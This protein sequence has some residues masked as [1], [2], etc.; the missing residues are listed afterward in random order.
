MTKAISNLII[1]L[2]LSGSLSAQVNP[3]DY[4][5]HSDEIIGHDPRLPRQRLLSWEKPF[6]NY[7][8]FAGFMNI[9]NDK[10]SM[11]ICAPDTALYRIFYF[12]G[13][14][15]E[16]YLGLP[17]TREGEIR[18]KPN[19]ISSRRPQSKILLGVKLNPNLTNY[20]SSGIRSASKHFTGY[21]I[22]DS[23]AV[24]VVA[25]GINASN[26]N[27]YRYHV[28]VNDSLEIV[29][30]TTP[31][32]E[33]KHGAKQPYGLI[34]QFTVPD[35]QAVI[36]VV[37]I[38]D[39]SIRDGVMLD[40]RHNQR[41]VVNKIT[42]LDY[43]EPYIM[44]PGHTRRYAS[45][46]DK[47]TG[48]PTDL[49]FPVNSITQISLDFKDHEGLMYNVFLTKDTDGYKKVL[50]HGQFISNHYD[51]QLGKLEM[52]GKYEFTVI[53]EHYT[54]PSQMLRFSFTII[55]RIPDKEHI[56]KNT[57]LYIL[58]AI[59]FLA[60]LYL[61]Y[62]QK[63][64]RANRQKMMIS[65][66]LKSVRAQLNPHFMFNALTSIQNLMN[67][68]NTVGANHYLSKF[69]DLTRRVLN[70][71]TDELISLEDELKIIND[72]LQIEQL[73]FGFQ[74][75]VDVNEGIN[76]ANTEIPAMLMQPFIENAIKHGISSL[77]D[78]GKIDIGITREQNNL[79]LIIADNGKGFDADDMDSPGF[80]LKLGRERVA[81]L[82]QLYKD[83]LIEL[84]IS[85][86]T[87]GTRV[88]I[89]LNSWF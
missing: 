49:K 78:N 37:N 52:P 14:W 46:F 89:T 35:K 63:L 39:Y 55:P 72:Y 48:L 40:W 67:Q 24:T 57:V 32:L 27:D 42:V 80:G 68:Q 65:L 64:R 1:L 69:A 16:S 76:L 3:A 84:Y 6:G 23:S 62:R 36:E 85:S 2:L 75:V 7:F 66:R 34:G 79:L 19:L 12:T 29:K 33:Q 18:P 86:G 47:A 87:W 26:V 56:S 28:I 45:K 31:K 30:W 54:D 11:I 13:E 51:L 83:Q 59:L 74:Y 41:P 73:R 4:N 43:T 8:M 77:L 25:M 10:F 15:G 21:L 22:S 88:I 5:F 81:L 17:Y 50:L 61:F 58:A 38:K 9:E 44:T 82:N 53:P 20:K 60:A 71:T 70:T